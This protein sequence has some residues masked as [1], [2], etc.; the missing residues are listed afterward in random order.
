MK[1]IAFVLAI[2]MGLA[3]VWFAPAC[4]GEEIPLLKDLR[5]PVEVKV[6][7]EEEPVVPSSVNPANQVDDLAKLC[8]AGAVW[9]V[10]VPDATALAK[11]WGANPLGA[12]MN[13][14]AMS[15]TFRNNRFGLTHLF[16]DLPSSI[17]T[18]ERVSAMASAIELAGILSGMAKKMTLASYIDPDGTFNF[19]VLFDVGLDRVPAFEI[20]NEWET[21]FLITH[22][23]TEVLRG[24]HSGNYL[25]VWQL[26]K[27]ATSVVSADLAAGFAENVVI[28]SNKS[29]LARSAM[30]LLAS[31]ADSVADTHWGERLAASI[32]SSSSADM[33]AFVRMDALLRGLDETPIARDSV[34]AWTDLIGQGAAG[35]VG[36]EGEA[37]YYGLQFAPDGSRETF[38]LPSAGPAGPGSLIELVAK[39]L[40]PGR[41]WLAPL[42]IPYQPNPS[43]YVAAHLDGPQL[44]G[45]LKQE[46]RLFGLSD[47]SDQFEVPPAVR[48]IFSND[49]V[50]LLTGEIGLA[51][52]S[53]PEQKT[54][55]LMVLPCK[56]NP[57]SLLQKAKSTIE[58]SG[59]NIRSQEDNWRESASWMAASPDKFRRLTQNYLL[60]ASNGDL[61]ISATDQLMSGSSFASNKDFI[62]AMSMAEADQGM[63]F[64]IN[65]PEILVREYPN[66][67]HIMRSLYPRSSGL[68]S[69]PPLALLRRY[70]KGLLGVIA[71]VGA[72]AEF[73]RVTVQSPGPAMGALAVGTVMGFPRAL[74][75]DGRH[76]M[77]KSRENMQNLWLR[78]QL[79]SSRFGHFPDTLGDLAA[80]MRLNMADADIRAMMTAPAALSRLAPDAAAAGSYRYLSGV[81]PSDEPDVP[82]LYEAEPWSEDFAGMYPTDPNRAPAES[83]D[84]QP[85]RQYIRLDGKVVVMTEKMFRMKVVPRLA[86]RE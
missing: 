28:V 29:A 39:R 53:A 64:Y 12:L 6:E 40:R 7:K 17:I 26:K 13:E 10:S 24:D 36:G 33:V 18:P 38:L 84:F 5:K 34:A 56:G 73:T 86:E 78:L 72:D 8:P 70:A 46:R 48:A 22:S 1:R 19:L 35:A 20:M 85:Y 67:S 75:A 3:A 77:E 15:R 58:R 55:W 47:R 42:V 71:P 62:R 61:L 27:G 52:F 31:G 50:T 25:D 57:E 69:R 2:V 43:L 66:L 81:T 45:L 23:G 41:E 79:Y 16:G 83:G 59:A 65:V 63:I 54:Q 11:N 4:A 14:T 37:M 60:V 80:D 76:S 82:L 9:F 68:N 30:T 44:G 32:P 74:R 21:S 49:V 51:F